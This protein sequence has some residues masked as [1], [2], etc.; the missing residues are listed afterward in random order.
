M[1]TVAAGTYFFPGNL[2][3]YVTFWN[4]AGASECRFTL[5]VLGGQAG[6]VVRPVF[7]AELTVL[8]SGTW[9]YF[10]SGISADTPGFFVTEW[11]PMNEDAQLIGDVYVAIV[12]EVSEEID[13]DGLIFGLAEV[14]IR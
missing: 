10:S 12:V 4:V 1:P 5:T 8:Q 3:D 11:E 9:A 14:Q 7:D 2:N 6:V 13:S